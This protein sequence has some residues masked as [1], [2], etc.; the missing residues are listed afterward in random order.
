MTD[1]IA[2]TLSPQLL[3]GQLLIAMPGL[4]DP[5]FDLSV[6][7]ICAH[8]EDGAMG[9]IINKVS[10]SVSIDDI[11]GQ[12]DLTRSTGMPPMPVHFGGPVERGRGF[13]L[14]GMDAMPQHNAL[15]AAQDAAQSDDVTDV[16]DQLHEQDDSEAARIQVTD[17]IAM[18]ASRDIL[19]GISNGAGPQDRL[20]CL[21]YAGWEPDQLEG[22]IGQNAWLTCAADFDIVFR[23]PNDGKW[24][25]ALRSMGVEP[26][27]LSGAAGHA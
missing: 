1:I 27:M 23:T 19:Q 3:T 6:V 13:V 22:E 24:E 20:L 18:T 12:L 21:G 16:A 17:R 25:A 15:T 7:Y 14:H 2:D 8:S 5:R 11:F 4:A 9:L 26:A 10:E